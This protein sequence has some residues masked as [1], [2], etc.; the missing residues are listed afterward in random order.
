M[1]LGSSF[2]LETWIPNSQVGTQISLVHELHELF[3]GLLLHI[4]LQCGDL[5]LKPNIIFNLIFG[6]HIMGIKSV[7]VMVK[8]LT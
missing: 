8:F 4:D 2:A 3:R 7:N 1:S 6:G 5:R